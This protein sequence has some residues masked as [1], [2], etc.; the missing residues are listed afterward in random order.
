MKVSFFPEIVVSLLLIGLLAHFLYPGTLLMPESLEM[1]VSVLLIIIFLIFS[2]F[3][4]KEKAVDERDHLHI[5][6]AGRISFFVGATVLVIGIFFQ[7]LEHEIDP[8][9][10]Y[11]LMAM[12][13]AKI[14]MRVFSHL[15][16]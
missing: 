15:K 7:S 12:I 2:A 8:F 1:F 6:N 16:Q 11:A 10:I 14:V 3:I 9:L 13:L 4:W 5:L